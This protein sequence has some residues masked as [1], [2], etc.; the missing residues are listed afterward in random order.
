M[1]DGQSKQ[2]RRR[3]SLKEM[4]LAAFDRAHKLR[5]R[6]ARRAA[7][8]LTGYPRRDDAAEAAVFEDICDF[9]EAVRSLDGPT[10]EA[11]RKQIAQKGGGQR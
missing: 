4:S 3:A 5:T 1:A 2:T 10:K 9:L 7:A 11:I 8:G 6:N